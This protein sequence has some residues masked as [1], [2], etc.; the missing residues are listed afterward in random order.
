MQLATG[1]LALLLIALGVITCSS[2]QSIST[3]TPPPV[4]E[5]PIATS[6]P[7]AT[8]TLAPTDTLTPTATLSPTATPMLRP[9]ATPVPTA[10]PTPEPTAT[11]IPTPT[12]TITPKPLPTATPTPEPTLTPTPTV[13]PIPTPTPTPQ[14][15]LGSR[16]RPIPFGV[17][18]ELKGTQS[19]DHWEVTVT[20][21]IPNANTQVLETN[22]YN[23]A[24]A[25]GKQFYIATVQVKYLGPYSGRPG[26]QSSF[27]TLGEGDSVYT[28]FENSCGV[29][30]LELPGSELFTN[31]EVIGNV[32]WEVATSD[33]GSLV[34]FVDGLISSRSPRVWFSLGGPGPAH[35][36]PMPTV[37]AMDVYD[38]YAEDRFRANLEYLGKWLRIELDLIDRKGGDGSV[39]M[40]AGP[41]TDPSNEPFIQ[42]TFQSYN[43]THQIREGD[44]I[45][46]TC[47]VEDF[48]SSWSSFGYLKF[49]QCKDPEANPG[50]R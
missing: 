20:N 3:P 33:I 29:I 35:A 14:P 34:M 13:T 1:L 30:P 49:T 40:I 43:D 38:A 2:P 31:A 21:T 36:G 12:P 41:R 22:P 44:A 27:R 45:A 28:S 46:A 23:G 15:R 26:G 39:R 10:T 8:P 7:S 19:K 6:V 32:C 37:N 18:T 47:I 50:S 17:A 5:A 11:A 16:D 4:T 48:N 24:P 25:E 9:T 42:L